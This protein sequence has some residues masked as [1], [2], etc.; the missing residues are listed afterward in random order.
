MW[1][2]DSIAVT[3]T[4]SQLKK[5]QIFSSEFLFILF[6][7]L[8]LLYVFFNCSSFFGSETLLQSSIDQHSSKEIVLWFKIPYQLSLGP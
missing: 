2:Y 4:V 6:S 8:I 7:M 5:P 3:S 1:S